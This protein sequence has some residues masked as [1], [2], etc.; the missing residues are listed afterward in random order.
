MTVTQ[1]TYTFGDLEITQTITQD[2][3]G[4]EKHNEVM[5]NH[6]DYWEVIP[7][8]SEDARKAFILLHNFKHST[9]V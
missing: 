2:S 5:K 1:N 7:N 8:E 6:G 3:R 9:Q 4:M